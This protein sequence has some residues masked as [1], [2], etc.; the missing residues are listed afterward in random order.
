[1]SYLRV[2]FVLASL[3]SPCCL[4][5]DEKSDE[6]SNYTATVKV[7]NAT[8]SATVFVSTFMFVEGQKAEVQGCSEGMKVEVIVEPTTGKPNLYSVQL[9]MTDCR[10]SAPGVEALAAALPV[11]VGKTSMIGFG[12]VMVE[13]T[14]A[15]V[16]AAD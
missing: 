4:S 7:T 13:A 16:S 6:I 9:K 5:A 11:C 15:P 3:A 1:M 10:D 8:E 14:I 2:F 12:E